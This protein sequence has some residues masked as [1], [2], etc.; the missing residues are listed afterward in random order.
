MVLVVDELYSALR[1]LAGFMI[2]DSKRNCE[3]TVSAMMR[4]GELHETANQVFKRFVARN[5]STKH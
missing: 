5:G 2:T 4:F 3:A 1:F